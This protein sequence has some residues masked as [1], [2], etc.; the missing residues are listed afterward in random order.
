MA[1]IKITFPD[2]SSKEFKA[3]ITPFEIA[4]GISHKLAE[5]AL[6]AAFN[7]E[8]VDLLA[9][10]QHDGA[11]K[12]L[13]YQDKE[14]KEVFWHSSSHLM[15]HAIKELFPEVKLTI[16]PVIEQGFYYDI[17]FERAFTPG[18]LEKIEARMHE[19]VKRNLQIKRS[20]FSRSDAI[21]KNES[22]GEPYK[23]EIIRDDAITKV[24]S[25]YE[26]GNF[27][28]MCRGPHV[29]STGYLKAFKLTKVSG[30]Y[31]RG[32]AK[33]KQLQR[34]YGISFPQK[35]DLEAYVSFIDE[36][37]KRDHRKLGRELE[38]F[39][40]HDEGPGFPFFLPKGMVLKNILLDFWR[41][42]HTKA[43]YVEIQTPIMLSKHLWVTSGHWENYR[44]NMYTTKIDNEDFAIKPMNCPGGLL[45]YKEKSHSYREL[46]MR[47]GEI[48]IVHR[49]ELS[50]VLSGLFRVRVFTQD[51]A[52]LF[53]RE[54]QIT[55]E[56]LGVINLTERFYKTF[57]FDF[58]VE[59][60]TR[61]AKSIG[62]DAQWA[63][64]E[65]ALKIAL[66]KKGWTYKINEG[67]GAFYGPKIDFHLKDALGRTWQCG[68]VQLDMN[69]PERF[70][71]TYVNEKSEK[72][73]PIMLH[74]VIF[75]SIERFMAILI[76]H[77]AG[78]FPLWL[79]PI[80]AVIV[81]VSDDH[82]PFAKIVKEELLQ[83]GFRVEIDEK[84]ESVS[85]KV[86]EA[87]VKKIPLIL[88]IGQKESESK[89]VAVRTLDG[90]VHHGMTI[91]ALIQ[92][93]KELVEKKEQ[94]F[95]LE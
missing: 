67:D 25:F 37:E 58:H 23:V 63:L 56:V 21:K 30:A 39:S 86:R 53:I 65:N 43:G 55:D 1:G 83:Q 91:D 70:D 59:L 77:Y 54:D 27:A 50:G 95:K 33:N 46:P 14:G 81:T 18:D 94:A 73:R 7:D 26:Q 52:H 93:V 84:R 87:Q 31:W 64:A 75:G 69:L 61:P 68:T 8:V 12:L 89:T 71:I 74:R 35:K 49:H 6:A 41:K 17:D 78:K 38:L 15:A 34:I 42:E 76:E 80:Q 28:D 11:L 19:I 5:S 92:K 13:T 3:G 32:D 90:Q 82:L 66:D 16:G 60:S 24:F 62:S 9:P 51:D 44:E 72:V 29:P 36:A 88:T 85:Y 20:E 2:G 4:K 57:G 40:I 48:G 45:V 10:L 79:A 47:V 22:L